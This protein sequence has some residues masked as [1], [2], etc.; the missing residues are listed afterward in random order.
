LLAL[1]FQWIFQQRKVEARR[2]QL[3]VLLSAV[4]DA[5]VGLLLQ[6]FSTTSRNG[7]FC[8]GISNHTLFSTERV[9]PE[10]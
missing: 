9:Y 8:A 3:Q 5:P 7:K 6:N 1:K 10:R 2:G 4:D